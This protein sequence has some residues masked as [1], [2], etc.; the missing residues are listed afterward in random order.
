MKHELQSLTGIIGN[1]STSHL[2][3]EL[4]KELPKEEILEVMA[5]YADK[6][7]LQRIQKGGEL[8]H[9]SNTY[10]SP[11]SLRDNNSGH[12]FKEWLADKRFL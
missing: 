3:Y 12:S 4:L 8:I 1:G 10:T 7:L 6:D 9:A 5:P 2:L 11:H